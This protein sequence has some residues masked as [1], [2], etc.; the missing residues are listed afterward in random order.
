[1]D[2][3][4]YIP[5]AIIGLILIIIYAL[6]SHSSGKEFNQAIMVNAILQASGLVCG[7]LLVAG[8]MNEEAKKLISEIDLYI[9]IAG[10]VILA[11]SVK[12]IYTD[13]FLS[14]KG[15]RKQSSNKPIKQD[16]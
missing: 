9:F 5:S 4:I 13:I 14:T 12:G 15:S 16:S 3:A 1:M 6:R 11:A 7:V 2:K 10:M 8:T